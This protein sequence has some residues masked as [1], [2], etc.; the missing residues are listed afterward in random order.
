MNDYQ[1]RHLIE[2]SIRS[3]VWKAFSTLNSVTMQN[4]LGPQLTLE[5]FTVASLGA[6]CR[7]C[8]SHGAFGLS[9]MGVDT[10]RIQDLWSFESSDSFSEADRAALRFALAAGKAPSDVTPEHHRE[11]RD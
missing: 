3:E 10:N 4:D 9:D 1:D 7:H 6:G 5:V 2:Q 11:M 8:Q